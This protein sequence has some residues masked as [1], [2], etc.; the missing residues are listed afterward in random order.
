MC[1]SDLVRVNG[2]KP[3]LGMKID[4]FTDTVIVNGIRIESKDNRVFIL[5]NKPAGVSTSTDSNAQDTILSYVHYKERLFNTFKLCREQEGLVLLCN[6]G[7][8]AQ[9]ISHFANNIQKE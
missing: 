1:S 6:D 3:T 5:F 2:Q 8:Y 9:K 4:P 7:E